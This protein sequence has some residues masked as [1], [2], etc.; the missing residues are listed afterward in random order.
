MKPGIFRYS[1]TDSNGK[2]TDD[3]IHFEGLLVKKNEKWK[4][5]MEYQKATATLQEWNA[6]KKND[7]NRRSEN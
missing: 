5:L 7:E 4:V 6:L 1:T 2:S 3:Y